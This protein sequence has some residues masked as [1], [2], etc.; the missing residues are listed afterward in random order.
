[1]PSMASGERICASIPSGRCADAF[2]VA[3]TRSMV[4]FGLAK[5]ARLAC[6]PQI[7]DGPPVSSS[8]WRRGKRSGGIVLR[9]LRWGG[10]L[11]IGALRLAVRCQLAG[12][13]A[14]DTRHL[15]SDTWG[16]VAEWLMA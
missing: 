13:R 3:T 8:N 2:R 12:A 11:A 6:T 1:M 10:G 7:Q 15:I 9:D 5:A 14:S 16:R 4:R